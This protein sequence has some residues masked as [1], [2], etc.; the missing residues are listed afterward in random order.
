MRGTNELWI[1]DKN[2]GKHFKTVVYHNGKMQRFVYHKT[3]IVSWDNE[4]IILYTG[5]YFTNT[6]KNKTQ[7]ASN[8]LNLGYSIHQRDCKWY[9]EFTDDILTLER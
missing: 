2:G 8:Q 6:T 3:D 5:G 1:T 9:V 4:K 7:R